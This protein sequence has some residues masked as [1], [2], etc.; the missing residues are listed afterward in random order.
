[1]L[2]AG[3][4]RGV[5]VDGLQQ[6]Y[7]FGSGGKAA[8]GITRQ[9]QALALIQEKEAAK[10]PDA[11]ALLADDRTPLTHGG[12]GELCDEFGVVCVFDCILRTS[13]SRMCDCSAAEMQY[14]PTH[15]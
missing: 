1:M 11:A 7:R 14:E 10:F 12:G 4:V 5:V 8:T 3:M 15:R 13:L 6:S 2:G 9:S